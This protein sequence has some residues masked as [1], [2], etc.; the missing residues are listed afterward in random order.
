MAF[1]SQLGE[2]QIAIRASTDQLQ[3]DL[4]K[5]K[6]TVQSSLAN[7]QQRMRNFG[8]MASIAITA[9]LVLFGKKSV[10]AAAAAEEMESE[11]G[12]MKPLKLLDVPLSNYERLRQ[13]PNHY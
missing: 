1:S 11:N 6:R 10:E 8:S 3:R 13:I 4:G 7:I 12:Q 2:A 9:P 5:V